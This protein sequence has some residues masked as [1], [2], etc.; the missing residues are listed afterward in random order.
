MKKL[1]L[2]LLPLLLGGVAFTAACSS[3]ATHQSTGEY[4]DDTAVTAKVKAAFVKDDVVKAV[5][6]NV[7]TYNGTVQL[8]GFTD[9]EMQRAR[10]EQIARGVHG[11][12]NVA[13]RIQLKAAPA[14]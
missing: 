1:L 14:R 9:T 4:L 3:T 12:Q 6:V 8:S 5:D 2:C 11:A 13:N 7:E 10:A